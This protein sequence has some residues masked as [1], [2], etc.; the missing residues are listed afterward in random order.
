MA[1]ISSIGTYHPA[2]I[3]DNDFFAAADPSQQRIEKYFTGMKERR[4][5]DPVKET[6]I[7]MGVKAAQDA[8]NKGDIDPASIDLIIGC[9]IPNQYLAPDDLNLIANGAGCKNAIVYSVFS[10]CSSFLSCVNVADAMIAS[11]K[12]KRVMIVNSSQ[13]A[14][15]IADHSSEAYAIAGD[16]AAATILDDEGDDFLDLEEMCCN[17]EDIFHSMLLKN[18][19]FTGEK[20]T[21]Q[22]TQ[23]DSTDNEKLVSKPIVVAK[24]LLDRQE[25]M[26]DHFVSHQA[27]IGM[28]NHWVNTLG[29]DEGKLLH[30]FP[31]YG[32]M[33]TANIPTTLSHYIDSGEIKRGDTILLFSPAAG[34]HYISILW[35]Y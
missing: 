22:I 29:L 18:P 21:F 1:R 3:V 19:V 26:P 13:W 4:H 6:G 11:G 28:L 16:G 35:R 5:A 32:N 8:L 14:N 12:A 24:T 7:I 17:D 31:L 20:E 25:V 10:A 15:T 34:A 23:V 30:T 9:V 27:G 2:K 33:I